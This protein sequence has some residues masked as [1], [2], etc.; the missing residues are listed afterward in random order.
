MYKVEWKDTA[1][2]GCA[3]EVLDLTAAL[4]RAKN[5]NTQVTIK[6]NGVE[7]VGIFG[8]SSVVNGKLPNGED[9]TW[10]KRRYVKS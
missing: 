9:Y 8:A 3:E 5:L 4:D 6:G 1:G 7:I 10:Y 2:V